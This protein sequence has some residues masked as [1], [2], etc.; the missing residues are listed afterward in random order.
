MK[1]FQEAKQEVSGGYETEAE[2]L[3]AGA[4]R[5]NAIPNNRVFTIKNGEKIV[6]AMVVA[7]KFAKLSPAVHFRAIYEEWSYS[8]IVQET[9]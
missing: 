9:H 6:E 2:R 4:K 1:K 3:L 7:L 5:F 8:R